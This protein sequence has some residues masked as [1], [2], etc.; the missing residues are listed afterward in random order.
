M[1]RA[2]I[3]GMCCE[4]CAQEVKHIFENIYGIS[5]VSVSV[6]NSSVL[7]D[8]FVSKRI[9]EESLEGTNYKIIEIE[10]L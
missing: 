7:Y 10:K 6:D 2:K 1:K 3:D 9:I 8:G 5:N 4:G